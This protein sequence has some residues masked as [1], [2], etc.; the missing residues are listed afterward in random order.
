[1]YQNAFSKSEC[2]FF[3]NLYGVKLYLCKSHT[4]EVL[5]LASHNAPCLP[6]P[7]FCIIFNF[8]QDYCSTHEK[9]LRRN[10]SGNWVISIFSGLK[11]KITQLPGGL[12][13]KNKGYAKPW[14]G[15]QGVS[16]MG[17]V[18][19]LELCASS[20]VLKTLKQMQGRTR[21]L[22]LVLRELITVSGAGGG[23]YIICQQ[24]VEE[25]SLFWHRWRN[26]FT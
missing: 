7:K 2:I 24:K 26:L 4:N 13:L 21:P 19:K 12:R 11:I 23:G 22:W 3:Q 9:K 18:Q 14:G 6:G 25:A 17:D 16:I 20:Q 10:L 5:F 1:M 8:S 15:K